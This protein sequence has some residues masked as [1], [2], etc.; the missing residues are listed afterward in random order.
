MEELEKRINE[1]NLGFLTFPV[2]ENSFDKDLISLILEE[3]NNII[4]IINKERVNAPSSKLKDMKFGLI[5]YYSDFN[6]LSFKI[7]KIDFESSFCLI[8]IKIPNFKLLEIRKN[9][10]VEEIGKFYCDL[11]MDILDSIKTERVI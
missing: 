7:E 10:D 5:E 2:F 11:Y 6:E 9:K 4:N 1:K 3:Q 8:S